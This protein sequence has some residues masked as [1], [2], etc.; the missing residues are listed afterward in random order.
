MNKFL[1]STRYITPLCTDTFLTTRDV[2][3]YLQNTNFLFFN[4]I[5]MVINICGWN[6]H[7]LSGCR[8]WKFIIVWNRLVPSTQSVLS[9]FSFEF[10]LI[11]KLL[12]RSVLVHFYGESSRVQLMFFAIVKY[13]PDILKQ[14]WWKLWK[15]ASTTDHEKHFTKFVKKNVFAICVESD[16]VISILRK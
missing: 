1:E 3:Y 10:N 2:S 13:L 6:M 16:I 11:Y 4:F 12:C 15:T 8:Q 14:M 7:L 5:L 9:A